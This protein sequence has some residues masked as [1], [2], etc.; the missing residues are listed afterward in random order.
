MAAPKKI[1]ISRKAL[2]AARREVDMYDHLLETRDRIAL[3]DKHDP[4]V[5]DSSFW[6]DRTHAGGW[7]EY[8][9]NLKKIKRK[10]KPQAREIWGGEPTLSLYAGDDT[11][12]V[13]ELDSKEGRQVAMKVLEPMIEMYRARVAKHG[14]EFED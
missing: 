7:I 2:E 11:D 4:G 12:F 6:D 9:D 10:R 5:P 14:I 8:E 3:L 1:K 13:L